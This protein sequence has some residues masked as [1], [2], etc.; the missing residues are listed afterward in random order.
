[1]PLKSN[2]KFSSLFQFRGAGIPSLCNDESHTHE[3]PL[4][5]I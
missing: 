3:S 5:L 1:M 2:E 4:Y